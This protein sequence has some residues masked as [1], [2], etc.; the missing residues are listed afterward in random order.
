MFPSPS[1]HPHLH[2]K[3]RSQ[4]PGTADP[5]TAQGEGHPK[6]EFQR[7]LGAVSLIGEGASSRSGGQGGP[8]SVLRVR[9]DLKPKDE[10]KL[11]RSK[12]GC[13]CVRMCNVPCLLHS[14]RGIKMN[15]KMTRVCCYI[16]L[17]LSN[18]TVLPDHYQ[19]AEPQFKIPEKLH[20]CHSNSLVSPRLCW[21]QALSHEKKLICGEI[22]KSP[23]TEFILHSQQNTICS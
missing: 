20:C 8:Q 21:T 14:N 15:P 4:M 1:V 16:K 23:G 19:P 13:G 17:C 7:S 12:V 5:E 10:Y 9:G 3:A 6:T 2:W 22:I 11:V 18:K